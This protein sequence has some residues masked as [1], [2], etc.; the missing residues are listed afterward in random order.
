MALVQYTC[1]G[2]ELGVQKGQKHTKASME[3]IEETIRKHA[4][5]VWDD[6]QG[7]RVR[8]RG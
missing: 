2:R 7:F 1:L 8:T 4:F 5:A 3:R 6:V